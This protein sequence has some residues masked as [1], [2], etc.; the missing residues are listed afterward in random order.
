MTQYARRLIK[1]KRTYLIDVEN[2][3]RFMKEDTRLTS[4]DKIV[5]FLAVKQ[6]KN[7]PKYTQELLDGTEADYEVV[8]IHT[9][10]KNAMDINICTYISVLLGKGKTDT[11][12][13]IVSKDKGYD[14]AIN[15]IKNKMGVICKVRRISLVD[16]VLAEDDGIS[17]IKEL[18]E[19]KYTKNCVSK[20]IKCYESSKDLKSYNEALV[21][22]LPKD[23][24]EIYKT[25]RY[26]LRKREKI[27]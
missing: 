23:A 10:D 19:N 26:I 1:V 8:E 7:L 21:K 16:H 24:A 13:Y 17:E 9:H 5:V 6:H 18:L 25:T 4:A 27:K 2:I 14:K 12:Y 22:A 15:F 3:A 11:E 20:V